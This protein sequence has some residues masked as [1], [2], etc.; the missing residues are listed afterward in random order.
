VLDADALNTLALH[1]ELWKEIPPLTILTPHVK[2]WERLFGPADSDFHRYEQ[3]LERA[4]RH[5]VI[6]VLKGH[7][8][9]VA[10]PDGRHYFNT[11]GNPGMATAGSGDVL[12]GI[13]TGLLA[14]GYAPEDAALAG[15]YVHGLSGD[16]AAASESEESL[17]A[18]DLIRHLGKTFRAIKCT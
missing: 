7:R 5:R 14:Q 6:I 12:T 13:L 1:P 11:T 17:V 9:L 3:T 4:A 15:V 18:S 10:L 8:S 2:E 16:L